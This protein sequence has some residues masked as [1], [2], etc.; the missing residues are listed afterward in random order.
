MENDWLVTV[1]K[2]ESSKAKEI[3]V[4]FYEFMKGVEGLEDQH[5]LVRDRLEN[6]VVFS[7]R[8]LGKETDKKIIASKIEY[9]LRNLIPE[10]NF[11]VEPTPEH[12]MYKYQAWP[13]RNTLKERGAEKFNAFCSLLSKLSALVIEMATEL[14]NK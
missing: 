13:W 10:K 14:R 4:D 1:F 12:K 9:K 5:F 7:F 8:V 2:C 3:L 11:V 6:E